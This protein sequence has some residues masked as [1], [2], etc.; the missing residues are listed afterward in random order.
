[1]SAGVN[2]ID[3]ACPQEWAGLVTDVCKSGQDW[4]RVSKGVARVGQGL[5]KSR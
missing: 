3:Q 1:M 4:S 5:V 2:G